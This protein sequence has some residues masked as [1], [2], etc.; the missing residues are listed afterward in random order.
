MRVIGICRFSYPAFG[1]FKRMHDSIE[2]REAYLY[3]PERLELRFR[4]FEMLTLPSIAAQT[5]K[6][7]TFLVV[8]GENMPEPWRARLVELCASVPQVKIVTAEPQRH[9]TAMQE[10]I[11]KELAGTQENALQFRLDDDD[12][13]AVNFVRA[14]RRTARLANKLSTDWQN[15]AIEYSNGYSVMLTPGGVLAAKIQA[16][17]YSCGLAVLFRPGDTKTVMNFPHHKLHHKMPTLINPLPEMFLRAL[18]TDNDSGAVPDAD[19]L[20]PLDDSQRAFMKKRFNVDDD[21][22]RASFSGQS[23]LRGKA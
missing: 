12:A 17:F 19:A 23:E 2:A 9:R 10:A 18:H 5:D 16:Q 20:Q 15:L 21:A 14:I 22:V 7:F 1:G 4:H 6:R 8:T 3:T 11:L 13:V